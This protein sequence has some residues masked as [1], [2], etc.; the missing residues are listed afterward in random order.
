M[1]KTATPLSAIVY[2][3]TL[4][5]VCSQRIS[6]RNRDGEDGIP[7]AYLTSLDKF[8]NQWIAT[9]HVPVMRTLSD[10]IERVDQFVDKLI[11][12]NTPAV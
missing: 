9:T 12:E 3:D 7:I 1:Q 8:Q 2:V 4:P 5:N 6:T 11:R 10:T